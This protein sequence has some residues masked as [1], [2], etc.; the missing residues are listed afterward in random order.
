M[1]SDMCTIATTSFKIPFFYIHP[2]LALRSVLR[3]PLLLVL[4]RFN[5]QT[6]W[7]PINVFPS[8]NILYSFF[9]FC[10]FPISSYVLC[11]MICKLIISR[12]YIR[13][14]TF[15]DMVMAWQQSIQSY[16]DGN[17]NGNKH[18]RIRTQEAKKKENQYFLLH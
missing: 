12:I 13:G 6:E 4:I 3:H 11:S 17:E 2:S 10:S 18:K 16:S 9:S 14:F 15:N 1:K 5:N 8:F 7:D